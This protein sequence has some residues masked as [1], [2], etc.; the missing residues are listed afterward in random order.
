MA[1]RRRSSAA[2]MVFVSCGGWY[3]DVVLLFLHGTKRVTL[4]DVVA[5]LS[6]QDHILFFSSVDQCFWP[7]L[8]SRDLLDGLR[9]WQPRHKSLIGSL[10]DAFGLLAG[11]STHECTLP[12]HAGEPHSRTAI[13]ASVIRVSL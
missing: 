7:T 6:H 12:T 8:H 2:S 9:D 1:E 13:D 5:F 10:F 4:L 3:S 11:K